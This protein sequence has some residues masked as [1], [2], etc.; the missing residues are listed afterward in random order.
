MVHLCR[1]GRSCL[2]KLTRAGPHRLLNGAVALF[3]MGK[4]FPVVEH[5][6]RQPGAPRVLYLRAVTRPVPEAALTQSG[7]ATVS[8]GA[9]LVGPTHLAG[10]GPVAV[11]LQLFYS[12][13]AFITLKVLSAL[14]VPT[15]A[16]RLT[17]FLTHFSIKVVQS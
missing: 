1:T 4:R 3:R 13:T 12:E 8:P 5:H 14:V 7:R 17:H 11:L 9:R 10:P 16:V 2:A 6:F 15:G